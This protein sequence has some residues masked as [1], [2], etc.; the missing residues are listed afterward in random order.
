M[1]KETINPTSW[2][3]A[4]YPKGFR[5]TIEILQSIMM[6]SFLVGLVALAFHGFYGVV[7]L[8]GLKLS[9]IPKLVFWYGAGLGCSLYW[10]WKYRVQMTKEDWK[11]FAIELPFLSLSGPLAL[12]LGF[13][14]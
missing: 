7:E 6:M 12:L 1:L 13:P 3:R 9:L 8:S 14:L 11:S 10:P 2:L 4:N 5:L